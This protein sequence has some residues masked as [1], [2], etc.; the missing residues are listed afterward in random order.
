MAK[1]KTLHPLVAA[2][3]VVPLAISLLT[4]KAPT[5]AVH[6]THVVAKKKHGACALN[7]KGCPDT[8]CADDKHPEDALLNQVKRQVPG[9]SHAKVLS[10]S[11]FATLQEEANSTVGQDTPLDS[12]ERA[13]L[14]NIS[15]SGGKVSEGDL[16][17]LDGFLVGDP[18]PN[19]SGESVNCGLS[20]SANNDFHIPFADD[21][22]KSPF[23]GIVAEM[24]PQGREE[25]HP[26]W[27]IKTLHKIERERR[28][29][30]FNGQ[31]LY[32]NKHRVNSDQDD[33]I[34]GQP[35]RF[36][37]FE[38]HPVTDAMVCKQADTDCSATDWETIA[39]FLKEK[40]H[41]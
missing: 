13:K 15:V 17:Q 8:G 4:P 1:R 25:G 2:S 31:L 14:R 20:G 37:L 41:P 3:T 10:W 11:D 30:R 21:P 38:V 24:I 32:D 7:L 40:P 39:E 28:M 9:S 18:H 29:V 26:D 35:P 19:D 27:T 36:S 6:A 16:V 22:D 33:P 5:A 23:E 34:G 12:K